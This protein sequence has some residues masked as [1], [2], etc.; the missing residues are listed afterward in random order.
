MKR[1]WALAAALLLAGCETSFDVID[2]EMPKYIG[3]PVENLVARL[4]MPNK[5]QTIMGRKVYVWSTSFGYIGISTGA[6]TTLA[7]TL[8]VTADDAG[9]VRR[10]D[11]SGN[12]GAC[13]Q[14]SNGLKR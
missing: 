10:Y 3:K 9:N 12:N 5:E 4:G 8:Q 6:S 2:K 7:C 11:L 13:E 1:L 14:F